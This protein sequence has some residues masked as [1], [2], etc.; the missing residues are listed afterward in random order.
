MDQLQHQLRLLLVGLSLA[1]AACGGDGSSGRAEAAIHVD[2]IVPRAVELARF[3]AGLSKP[4]SLARGAASRDALVRGFMRALEQRDTA[5]LS[6]L[7]LTKAEFAY[8]YYPTNPEAQ[9]PY[10]LSPGLM[11]FMLEGRSGRGL[12]HLLEERGGRPLRFAGYVCP[13]AAVGEGVN[14][15]WAACTVRHGPPRALVQEWM[16]GPIVER[17]GRFKFVSY[18][19]KL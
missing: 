15:V 16:F 17:G 9:P 14:T 12:M 13:L 11:W 6:R 7:L 19:N 2:S 4:D 5:S 18:A 3:R 8:L 1:A 10:D